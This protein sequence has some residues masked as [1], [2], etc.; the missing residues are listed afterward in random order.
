MTRP[1]SDLD[2]DLEGDLELDLE[3]DNII[4]STGYRRVFI[5]LQ[6]RFV[7][8]VITYWSALAPRTART[9][10]TSFLQC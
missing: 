10:R 7:I 1:C 8:G 3:L 9:A 5:T 2:L 4:Q 6:R